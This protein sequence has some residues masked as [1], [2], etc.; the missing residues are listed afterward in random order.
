MKLMNI[1]VESGLDLAAKTD[2][3]F[4]KFLG[5]KVVVKCK[6]QKWT[7]VLNFAGINELHGKFQ[8]TLNRTPL[9]PVDPKTIKLAPPPNKPIGK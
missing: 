6:G 3:K 2:P 8:V 5:K 1:L 9:W 7:G 4:K